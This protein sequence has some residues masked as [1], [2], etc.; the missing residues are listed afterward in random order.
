MTLPEGSFQYRLKLQPGLENLE[1]HFGREG[2][3]V[4][5]PESWGK[6]WP[7]E[8]RVGF[9]GV[10]HPEGGQAIHLLVEKDFVC[11][12]RDLAGQQ[13]QYPHPKTGKS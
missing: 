4:Q 8:S 1:A 11:L 7:S 6:A 9:E 10:Q 3:T 12:D 5:L 2:I 13:D